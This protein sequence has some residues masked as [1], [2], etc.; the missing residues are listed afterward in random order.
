ML[1]RP[2]SP[3]KDSNSAQSY[4]YQHVFHTILILRQ[5][6]TFKCVFGAIWHM[7]YTVYCTFQMHR[8][9]GALRCQICSRGIFQAVK[10]EREIYLG[11]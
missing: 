10:Y 4:M 7:L 9:F 3:L 1:L 8:V 6:Y 11:N 5:L 2:K